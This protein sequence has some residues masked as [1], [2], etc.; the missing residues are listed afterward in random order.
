MIY[1]NRLDTQSGTDGLFRLGAPDLDTEPM[2]QFA[3]TSAFTEGLGGLNAPSSRIFRNDSPRDSPLSSR[4]SSV[5][6]TSSSSTRS[7]LDSAASTLS[8][9][10]MASIRS[11][12]SQRS[13]VKTPIGYLS[14]V[15]PRE[16]ARSRR[17]GDTHLGGRSMLAGTRPKGWALSREMEQV[18]RQA[19]ERPGRSARTP[20]K[21]TFGM[22]AARRPDTKAAMQTRRTRPADGTSRETLKATP[23]PRPGGRPTNAAGRSHRIFNGPAS[24]IVPAPPAPP[25]GSPRSRVSG[26]AAAPTSSSKAKARSPRRPRAG[27]KFVGPYNNEA[28]ILTGSSP[29]AAAVAG[30]AAGPSSQEPSP[31]QG[32]DSAHTSESANQS[33]WVN[34]S[35]SMTEALGIATHDSPERKYF[36]PTRAERDEINKMNRERAIADR[37]ARIEAATKRQQENRNK[38]GEQKTA[39]ASTEARLPPPT[40]AGAAAAAANERSSVKYIV[41][42]E[43]PVTLPSGETHRPA[44]GGVA[45]PVTSARGHVRRW[46]QSIEAPQWMVEQNRDK[47]ALLSVRDKAPSGW[48]TDY[49]REHMQGIVSDYTISGDAP[50]WMVKQMERTGRSELIL[51]KDEKG[52]WYKNKGIRSSGFSS[53]GFDQDAD[54]GAGGA[55]GSGVHGITDS[56][57]SA[58]MPSFFTEANER[59]D[60]SN[61]RHTKHSWYN[62]KGHVRSSATAAHKKGGRTAAME[63]SSMD[64]MGLG[65]FSLGGVRSFVDFGN[66]VQITDSSVSGDAPTWMVEM[67]ERVDE[68]NVVRRPNQQLN[69]A[70]KSFKEE[71]E[72]TVGFAGQAWTDSTVSGDAPSWMTEQNDRVDPRIV[73]SH[74]K[75]RR[76]WKNKYAPESYREF[77]HTKHEPKVRDPRGRRKTKKRWKDGR[78]RRQDQLTKKE[79]QVRHRPRR[80]PNGPVMAGGSVSS[81]HTTAGKGATYQYA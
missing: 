32:I 53:S 60:K 27:A 73:R 44:L 74:P 33:P 80:G 67:S 18:M 64:D 46:S 31:W 7:G 9:S 50:D 15:T 43:H 71:I 76:T 38:G 20:L 4:G 8:S 39:T 52:H 3:S 70:N 66:G 63:S 57:V 1:N 65:H 49:H 61:I 45:E 54:P 28:G 30:Q 72:K 25:P 21:S 62:K 68:R 13:N 22:R 11:A 36:Q 75:S 16:S 17:A 69:F 81:T 23:R 5:F 42:R 48:A 10:T 51:R 35:A 2:L 59:I 19:P 78:T 41:H 79:V 26:G 47:T 29:P 77:P 56:T 55:G 34:R 58:D 6:T 12:D 37:K 40:A 24:P 14:S